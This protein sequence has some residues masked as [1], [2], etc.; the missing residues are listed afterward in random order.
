MLCL[1]G[2]SGF[3]RRADSHINSVDMA[4]RRLLANHKLASG[5]VPLSDFFDK[6]KT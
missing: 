5:S 3:P 6:I 2:A 1:G 4:R